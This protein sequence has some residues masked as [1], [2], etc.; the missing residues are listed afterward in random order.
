MVL[1]PSRASSHHTVVCLLLCEAFCQACNLRRIKHNKYILGP[2]E[3]GCCIILLNHFHCALTGSAMR[4]RKIPSLRIPVHTVEHDRLA[5]KFSRTRQGPQVCCLL[6]AGPSMVHFTPL[7]FSTPLFKLRA[8]VS[9]L[10]RL[11]RSKEAK[12]CRKRE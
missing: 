6:G 7:G 5:N 12:C 2:C 11:N 9:F 4:N 8:A 1:S 3:H 10:Q